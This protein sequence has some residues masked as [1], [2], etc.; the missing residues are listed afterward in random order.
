M[1]PQLDLDAPFALG[2]TTRGRPW[3]RPRRGGR[4]P[5]AYDWLLIPVFDPYRAPGAVRRWGCDPVAA[6]RRS[7]MF[8]GPEISPRNRL[9]LCNEEEGVLAALSSFAS[10]RA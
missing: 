5:Q 6:P 4:I 10:M 8:A 1:R 2:G 7:K 9:R 3:R